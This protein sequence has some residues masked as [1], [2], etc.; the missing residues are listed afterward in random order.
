MHMKITPRQKTVVSQ[1]LKTPSR[2]PSC[3]AIPCATTFA[4]AG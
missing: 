1:K 3:S 2:R 4:S